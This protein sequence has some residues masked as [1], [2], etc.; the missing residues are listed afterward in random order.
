MAANQAAQMATV[1]R[2]EWGA[3]M[4]TA[5]PAL[6]AP[7]LPS[8]VPALMALPQHVAVL[9]QFAQMDLPSTPPLSPPALVA[10]LG[11][12]ME[13]ILS[14][15]MGAGQ[16]GLQGVAE[17]EGQVVAEVAANPKKF[18]ALPCVIDLDPKFKI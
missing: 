4:E 12:V 1:P 2:E 7:P 6:M 18:L 8:P 15:G 11:A 16:G 9:P 13:L 10:G 5:L 3:L 17:A 14:V